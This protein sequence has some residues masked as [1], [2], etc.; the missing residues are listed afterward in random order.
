MTPVGPLLASMTIQSTISPFV[1]DGNTQQQLMLCQD[2]AL[3]IFLSPLASMA[4][5]TH[6]IVILLLSFFSPS[7]ISVT[8]FCFNLSIILLAPP[9]IMLLLL[10][11]WSC[12]ACSPFHDA[13]LAIKGDAGTSGEHNFWLGGRIGLKF[14]RELCL[15]EV[16][17][18]PIWSFKSDIVSTFFQ[19]QIP[20]SEASKWHFRV[21]SITF[22]ICNRQ[23]FSVLVCN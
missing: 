11:L 23:L 8:A 2:H 4:K 18:V 3:S 12:C 1:I 22:Y 16:T 5:G 13:L 6:M 15:K 20:S 14:Y 10:F 19:G 21:F 9:I 17:T 7:F